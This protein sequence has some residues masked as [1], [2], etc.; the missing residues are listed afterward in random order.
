[1][2]RR[3]ILW[4]AI[5]VSV[6]AAAAGFACLFPF[7][8]KADTY[9]Q[10]IEGQQQEPDLHRHGDTP[11]L[12]AAQRRADG[13]MRKRKASA[14]DDEKLAAIGAAMRKASK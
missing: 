4:G 11:A 2:I 12:K 8:A 3:I 5:A 6:A 14:T 7:H 10:V 1:M 9:G 13:D